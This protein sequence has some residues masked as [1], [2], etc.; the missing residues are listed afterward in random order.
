[1]K[2]LLASYYIK[3]AGHSPKGLRTI[4]RP[5]RPRSL[6]LESSH[7]TT[8][9]NASIRTRTSR[10]TSNL[11]SATTIRLHTAVSRAPIN[12]ASL[13][14][15]PLEDTFFPALISP[16]GTSQSH[17]SSLMSWSPCFVPQPNPGSFGSR[18]SAVCNGP[19]AL[20][21]VPAQNRT[22]DLYAQKVSQ[23]RGASVFGDVEN[24]RKHKS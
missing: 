15:T 16:C 3:G 24:Y 11:G 19:I 22:S 21:S 12:S 1:M 10:P 14:L 13:S 20:T 6:N 7:F 23:K 18:E 9:E 17:S 4:N 8:P 2:F 5:H